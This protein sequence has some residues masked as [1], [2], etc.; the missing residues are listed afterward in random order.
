MIDI[1]DL[2]N[3]FN[4]IIL[5]VVLYKKIY[6]KALTISISLSFAAFLGSVMYHIHL[7]TKNKM[8]ILYDYLTSKIGTTKNLELSDVETSVPA[9][10]NDGPSVSYFELRESLIGN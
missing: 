5:M 1:L 8:P 2:F 4:L 6:C 3:M 7:E 9:D 10:K